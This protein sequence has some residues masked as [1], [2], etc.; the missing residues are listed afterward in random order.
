MEKTFYKSPDGKLIDS[1]STIMSRVRVP[2]GPAVD[3]RDHFV[4][5]ACL[6]IGAGEVG[7]MDVDD[8]KEV[9]RWLNEEI[10][11]RVHP[12]IPPADPF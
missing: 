9:V 6:R 8:L 2:D 7:Q 5:Q 3:P 12:Y 4:Q 10:Y 11:C 1:V